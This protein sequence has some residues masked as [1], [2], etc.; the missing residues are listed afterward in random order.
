MVVTQ[1][2]SYAGSPG[3]DNL[4]NVVRGLEARPVARLREHLYR[5]DLVEQLLKGDPE[6]RYRR[7]VRGLDLA[8]L[9]D[10]ARSP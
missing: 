3:V 5:P 7:A 9:W 6:H 8:K 2:G 4:I 1:A 10:A